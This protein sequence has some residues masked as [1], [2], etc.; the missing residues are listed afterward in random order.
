MLSSYVHFS[1]AVGE[2]KQKVITKHRLGLTD[3][4]DW[5]HSLKSYQLLPL[6]TIGTYPHGQ[7]DTYTHVQANTHA[8]TDTFTYTYTSTYTHRETKW[9][10]FVNLC[11]KIVPFSNWL[12]LLLCCCYLFPC[13]T[14]CTISL[15]F[16]KTFRLERQK[17][18]THF[19]PSVAIQKNIEIYLLLR[20]RNSTKT[21]HNT[22]PPS[23][24][25]DFFRKWK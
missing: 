18:V 1:K 10:S 12:V 3:L 4:C 25:C 5:T 21:T 11:C 2:G 6:H 24:F 19:H 15:I 8:R 13:I 16:S 7:T 22:Y 17:C 20:S 9:S 23:L 14:T